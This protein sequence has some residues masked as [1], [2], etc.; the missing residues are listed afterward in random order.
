MIEARLIGN[1]HLNAL[2]QFLKP[3]SPQVRQRFEAIHVLYVVKPPE[4]VVSTAEDGKPQLHALLREKLDR[5][6]LAGLPV[7]SLIGGADHHYLGL[8]EHA[9]PFDFILPEQPQLPLNPQAEVLPYGYCV[10]VMQGMLGDTFDTLSG[11]RQCVAGPLWHMEN[12]APIEDNA[13]CEANLPPAF[14]RPAYRG[15]RVAGPVLRYKV[16]RLHRELV[17]QHCERI[18]IRFIA[19][20][21]ES[22]DEHGFLKPAYWPADD[23]L[24]GNALYGQLVLDQVERL[25]EAPGLEAFHRVPDSPAEAR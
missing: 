13:F 18:G 20:P 15:M 23:P 9:R 5:P 2:R 19:C 7:F 16:A 14:Q 10:Q 17:R 1:S 21:A 22:M 11:L 3:Q 12:P 4:R 6:D 8:F 25:L 24:H